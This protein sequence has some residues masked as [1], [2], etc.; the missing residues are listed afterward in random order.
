MVK[1]IIVAT[2]AIFATQSVKAGRD[3]DNKS[4]NTFEAQGFEVCNMDVRVTTYHKDEPGADKET[5]KGHTSTGAKLVEA[6]LG[7]IGSFATDPKVI[8]YGSLV[9]VSTKKGALYYLA[10]DTG[11]AVKKRTASRKLAK[12]ARL[13]PEYATRPVVD[14]YSKQKYDNWMSV[15]VLKDNTSKKLIHSE[16]KARLKE[17]MSAEFWVDKGGSVLSYVLASN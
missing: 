3:E 8:P 4:Y 13:G 6:K 5:K 14:I 17:R 7:V 1:K 15:T 11:G 16:L 2:F 9:I 10:V 12:K